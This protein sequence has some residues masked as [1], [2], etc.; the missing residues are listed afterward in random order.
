MVTM[1]GKTMVKLPVAP[2]YAKMIL[3][4]HK[5]DCIQYMIAVVSAL[6]VKVGKIVSIKATCHI[7]YVYEYIM[8]HFCVHTVNSIFYGSL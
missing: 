2:R 1:L 6:T 8:I 4:A 7:L 5:E 3:L